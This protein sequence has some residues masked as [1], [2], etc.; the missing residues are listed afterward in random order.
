VYAVL[1]AAEAADPELRQKVP[2]RWEKIA[3]LSTASAWRI[4]PP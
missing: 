4:Y 1:D 3:D 2:G